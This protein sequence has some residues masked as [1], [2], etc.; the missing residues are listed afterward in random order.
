MDLLTGEDFNHLFRDFKRS[1]FHLEMQDEY[2][3]TE[4]VEPFR[5]WRSGEPDDYAWIRDWH[6]LIKSATM[7][8]KSVARARVVTEPV[9][10]YVRFEHAMA[11]FNVA[12]GERLYWLPRHLATGIDFPEHDF[13]LLDEETVAFNVFTD[14]GSSFGAQLT[15]DA[16]AVAGCAHVRDQVMAVGIPHE[17]YVLR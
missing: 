5:K 15:T 9:T 11:R 13:W 12:A 10:D 1:A 4:E 2:G 16:A 7:A 17:R 3:V 14:D 6:E 8:G